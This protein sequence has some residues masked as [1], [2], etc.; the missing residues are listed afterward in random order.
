MYLLHEQIQKVGDCRRGHLLLELKP[1]DPPLAIDDQG[2]ASVGED[3]VDQGLKF[4]IVLTA[5]GE[6]LDVLMHVSLLPFEDTLLGHIPLGPAHLDLVLAVLGTVAVLVAE[7][8]DVARPVRF[9]GQPRDG[10]D[11]SL[12]DF[13]GVLLELGFDEREVCE[14]GQDE[15]GSESGDDPLAEQLIFGVGLYHTF[16]ILSKLSLRGNS[17]VVFPL[18]KMDQY[19]FV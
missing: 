17:A 18:S 10:I 3:E 16:F 8:V 13:L 5:D 4:D 15:V 14:F 7:A 19:R 12:L 1:L 6:Y 2:L 11:E 9:G